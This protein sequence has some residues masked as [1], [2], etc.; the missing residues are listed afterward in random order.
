MADARTEARSHFKKGMEAIANGHYEIGIVELKRANEILP[1]PNVVYNIARAYAESGDLENAVA[2]YN[3]YLEGDPSDADEVTQIVASLLAR[4]RRQQSAASQAS[5]VVAP[6]KAPAAEEPVTP[7]ESVAPPQTAKVPV[8][9]L[10]TGAVP[11][12]GAPGNLGRARTEDVF[13]ETVVTA[14]KGA[15]S[16]L[17]APNSTSIVTEQDIRLSGI[18]KIPELLRRL[19]GVDIMEVT[20]AQTE[21][22]IRGFNQRLSNKVLVL[23][24]GRSFYLDSLGATLWSALTIGVEDIERIEVVRGP[25]SA[26]YGAD[27]FNGV[28]NII[29]KAPGKGPSGINAGF[30]DH[31]QT[32][33]S[34]WVTGR[35]KDFAWRASAGYDYLPRWS[36][37]VPD[38]RQDLS[39][40]ST[41]QNMSSRTTRFDLRGTEQLGKGVT[42]GL[43]GGL[44]QGDSEI[45]G[46]GPL[47][48]VD[49]TG[50]Q[51]TDITAFLNSPSFEARVFWK[52]F[53][54][55]FSLNEA[56]IGQSLLPG[57][58][59]ENVVDG[60]VQYIGKFE[61][62]KSVDHDLHIGLNYRFKEVEWSYLLGQ[63]E[64]NHAGFLAHDAVK[65]GRYLG[66]VGDIRVDYDP[67]LERFIPSPRGSVLVH[68]SS[69]S[70]VR[71]TVATAF[72]APTFLESYLDLPT[73]LPA[74]GGNL[75]AQ[76]EK[77]YD[78]TFKVQPEQI[79]TAELGYLNQESDYF[80]VDSAAYFNH[81]SDLIE[82]API[83]PVTVSNIEQGLTSAIPGA[84]SYPIFL[85]GFDNQC[86]SYNVYGGE[87][88]VRV[89]PVE[90]LD[91]YA[92]ST[93]NK[94]QQDNSNCTAAQ[95]ALFTANGQ[96]VVDQRTSLLKVNTGVQLRTK[97]GFNGS[98]DFHY[99][100][101]QVWAEQVTNV[102]AQIIQ[103]QAFPLNAYTL[104][105][106]RLG[107]RFLSRDRAEISVVGFNILGIQ[108]REH[109]F[110][111]LIGP[112]I[113][114]YFSYRF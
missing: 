87:L 13:E 94:V 5:Q 15:Q 8:E 63:E 32:H 38:G 14:S 11:A 110:G 111:Q 35:D 33:G 85:G 86:Q 61:T 54:T 26:L 78:P 25:G 79:F 22:S 105:N 73:Q 72:R 80:V 59:A 44:S 51:A 89:F 100:S 39:L 98:V 108:H 18:T 55:P 57:E 12:G 101:P 40:G 71:G 47:N 70:T 56:T 97:V 81:A 42:L 67:Y 45:L 103:Y 20:G 106:A 6:A 19:A 43:G 68:P 88:G 113:M 69:K 75:L 1:H 53:R 46:I 7:S 37:E 102:Q 58:I 64:E 24:D 66:L 114:G 83:T 27:A 96:P 48:D 77:A 109:P 107:F 112:R 93:L 60:E 29:T 4:I 65:L 3:R 49:L 91:I 41:D 21:V 62:G 30:G 99:V 84:G 104:L 52:T 82:L 74:A 50:F 36:R 95:L 92:N 9:R 23:V 10:P 90:G 76:E 16:P 34:V 28:I 2:F 17:D 31:D